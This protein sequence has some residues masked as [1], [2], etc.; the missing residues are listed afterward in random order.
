MEEKR[1][2]LPE[3]IEEMSRR[4]YSTKQIRDELKQKGLR[5][6]FNHTGTEQPGS[7]A[8]RRRIKQMNAGQLPKICETVDCGRVVERCEGST[9][10]LCWSCL[11]AKWAPHLTEFERMKG[12]LDN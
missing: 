12:L 11:G 4:G 1:I 3:L 7:R 9:A 6:R 8:A 10:V 5:V 2:S